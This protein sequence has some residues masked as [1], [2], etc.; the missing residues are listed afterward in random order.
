MHYTVL[1][2]VL[3]VCASCESKYD[4]L[5][6]ATAANMQAPIQELIAEF[7]KT[8]KINCE[9]SVASSGKL[10]AQIKN[11]A[12]FDVFVSADTVYPGQLFS[13][14]FTIDQPKVYGYG[15]LC[16]CTTQGN[17][18]LTFSYAYL[19]TV[20]KIAIA[21]PEIAPY[22]KATLEALKKV[23][24]DHGDKLLY[25]ES[26][27][28]A[29]LF[30]RSGAATV[31]ILSKSM[32]QSIEEEGGKCINI[33]TSLYNPIAQAVVVIKDAEQQ[34]AALEFQK[35][36]LSSQGKEILDKFGYSQ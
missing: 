15:T 2:S 34:E 20:G 24:P 29:A 12:P 13:E 23:Y 27:G 36:L 10:T 14:N 1:L 26:I 16:L 9:L 17:E 7:E 18:D 11:G 35:F 6:I 32:Q 31:G 28:Q 8:Q 33:K 19:S 21:N 22:G 3:I 30:V 4:K 5:L 25:G